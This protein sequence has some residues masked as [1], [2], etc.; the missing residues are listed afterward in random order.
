M[1]HIEPGTK[2]EGR[3]FYFGLIPSERGK[4]KSRK[5]HQRALGILQQDFQARYYIGATSVHNKPMVNTFISNGC[6]IM[7]SY[8]V[9]KRVRGN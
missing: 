3:L 7:E 8:K 2:N 9:Y 5:L 6:E 4:G 1:P